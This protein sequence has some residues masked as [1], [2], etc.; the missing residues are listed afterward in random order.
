MQ[1]KIKLKSLQKKEYDTCERKQNES[2]EEK[3]LFPTHLI[4]LASLSYFSSL[5]LYYMFDHGSKIRPLR[6]ALLQSTD[7]P[8]SLQSEQH[9]WSSLSG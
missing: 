8:L 3:T 9:F 2:E 4:N 5:L 1:G 6:Q 7:G